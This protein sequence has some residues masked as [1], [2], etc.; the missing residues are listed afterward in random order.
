MK[1]GLM[2]FALAAMLLGAAGAQA[3]VVEERTVTTETTNY[4]GTVTEVIPSSSTLVVRSSPAAAPVRYMYTDKTTFVDS[5]GNVVTRESIANKPV[6]V[7][8]DDIGGRTEVSKVVVQEP[9]TGR[10]VEE[11]VETKTIR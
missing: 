9:V 10:V 3:G 6:V 1:K 4:R 2:S 11:R 7:Y 8:Y 5:A